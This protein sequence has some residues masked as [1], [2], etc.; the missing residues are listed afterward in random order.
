M[1]SPTDSHSTNRPEAPVLTNPDSDSAF[2]CWH[3]W[4]PYPDSCEDHYDDYVRT[5][6]HWSKD[7]V[8]H[9]LI[10]HAQREHD[11]ALADLLAETATFEHVPHT[12]VD[13]QLYVRA[14]TTNAVYR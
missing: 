3:V 5:P 4:G 12:M 6:R 11:V 2:Q 7:Q 13:G 10:Q 9:A 8:Q 1:K 14:E